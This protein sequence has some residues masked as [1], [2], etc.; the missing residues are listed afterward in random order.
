[1]QSSSLPNRQDGWE[2]I[3]SQEVR[4][5][6]AGGSVCSYLELVESETTALRKVCTPK[7]RKV[8]R[9]HLGT[10]VDRGAV[11]KDSLIGQGVNSIYISTVW[12]SGKIDARSDTSALMSVSVCRL[13]P[14]VWFVVPS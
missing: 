6:Q 11:I 10:V 4:L 12:C 8:D 2:G 7:A 9:L 1:V 13:V 5:R 14:S 3:D